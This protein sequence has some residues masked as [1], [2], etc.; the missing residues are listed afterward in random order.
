MA[1]SVKPEL[2]K[3]LN[4]TEKFFNFDIVT[5]VQNFKNIF[6]NN[7]NR[8]PSQEFITILHNFT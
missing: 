6:R 7:G 3:I 2:Q 4:F 1:F 5:F 8:Q